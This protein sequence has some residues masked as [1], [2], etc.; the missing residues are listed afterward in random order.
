MR[1]RGIS[2]IELQINCVIIGIIGAITL[3]LMARCANR[4]L[5]CLEGLCAVRDGNRAVALLTV[6]E[7]SRGAVARMNA[8]LGGR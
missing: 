3:P 6:G 1:P 5:R 2:I 8:A 4:P 7:P